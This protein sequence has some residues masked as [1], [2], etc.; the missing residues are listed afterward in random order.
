MR[1]GSDAGLG[2]AAEQCIQQCCG[3]KALALRPT[4]VLL[5][6]GATCP[7]GQIRAACPTR[8]SEQTLQWHPSSWKPATALDKPA[9]TAPLAGSCC[10]CAPAPQLP[11]AAERCS[12][13]V[14]A[15]HSRPSR[16]PQQLAAAH[17]PPPAATATTPWS[18]LQ[19]GPASRAPE[20][21]PFPLRRPSPFTCELLAALRLVRCN[22]ASHALPPPVCKRCP[23]V[24]GH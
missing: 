12:L 11:S 7:C 1:A 8:R 23:A 4:T 24:V 6:I 21:W 10:R 15:N 2:S 14:I 13:A 18:H 3:C 19:S 16:H 17:P 20:R 22:A 5:R 9:V